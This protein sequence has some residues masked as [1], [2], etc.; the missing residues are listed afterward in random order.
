M[1]LY[2]WFTNI[3]TNDFASHESIAE[4]S[5]D[6]N[7]PLVTD[8]FESGIEINPANGLPMIDGIGSVDIDGNPYGIDFSDDDSFGIDTDDW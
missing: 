8:P 7:V 6:I 3:F 5:I 2:N 4:E 1:R